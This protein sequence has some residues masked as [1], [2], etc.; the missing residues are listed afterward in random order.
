MIIVFLFYS[1]YSCFT[2]LWV[3][4]EMNQLYI[5][6]SYMSLLFLERLV[7]YRSLQS[8]VEAP[9]LQ[10]RT[11]LL[12]YSINTILHL[13]IPNSH[14][15]PPSVLCVCFRFVEKFIGAIFKTPH[16]SDI[17]RYLS[18]FSWLTLLSVII[19]RSIH[20]VAN[21]IVSFFLWLSNTPL[22]VCVCV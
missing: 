21:G 1:A 13:L 15:P 7:P 9:V 22:C 10:S 11:L 8:I 16:I 6:I 17:I 12:I 14:S 3:S 19:S 20:V 5:H 2:M 4:G 18:F